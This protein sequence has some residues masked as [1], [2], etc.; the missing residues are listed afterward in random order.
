MSGSLL[1]PA[2]MEWFMQCLETTQP[3]RV[4]AKKENF[5]IPSNFPDLKKRITRNVKYFQNNYFFVFLGLI[6]YRL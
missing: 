2:A 6:L 4:F 3:W 1:S 5:C